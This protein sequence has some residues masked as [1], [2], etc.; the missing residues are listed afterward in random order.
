MKGKKIRSWVLTL[1]AIAC[2]MPLAPAFGAPS[3]NA[4]ARQEQGQPSVRT[5]YGQVVKLKNGKYALMINVQTHK[6]YFLD[7]QKAARKYAQ[8]N[9]LVTGTIDPKSSILHVKTIKAAH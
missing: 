5:Y 1:A 3:N 2:L 7:K 9:V 8:K 4:A 6:G